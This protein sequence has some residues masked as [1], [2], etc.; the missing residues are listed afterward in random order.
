MKIISHILAVAA[1]LVL[2]TTAEAGGKKAAQPAKKAPKSAPA[3]KPKP[4][5][6]PPVQPAPAKIQ[7]LVI[8][9]L[10]SKEISGNEIERS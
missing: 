4:A 7:A 2:S 6:P 9:P 5:P 1:C 8:M 3:V 10:E